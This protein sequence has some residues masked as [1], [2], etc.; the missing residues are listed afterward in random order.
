LNDT[1]PS[2]WHTTWHL[3][4]HDESR[5]DSVAM[6]TQEIIFCADEPRDTTLANWRRHNIPQILYQLRHDTR[7]DV[8]EPTLSV[9]TDTVP[10]PTSNSK[11]SSDEPRDAMRHDT[12]KPT[13]SVA[14]P[15]VAKPTQAYLSLGKPHYT[16]L[17]YRRR[18]S[19]WRLKIEFLCTWASGSQ[20][21]R[22]R[23]TDAERRDANSE[24]QIKPREASGSIQLRNTDGNVPTQSIQAPGVAR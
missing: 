10:T 18:T 19:R 16:T 11:S 1:W 7:H 2:G 13:P 4:T 3:Q 20:K 5:D 15:V 12:D 8:I 23:K 21:T 24:F 17:A 9:A 22:G 14:T 6:P